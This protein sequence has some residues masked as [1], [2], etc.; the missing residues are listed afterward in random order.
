MY[1]RTWKQEIANEFDNAEAYMPTH[2]HRHAHS[3]EHTH[4]HAHTHALMQVIA[5]LREKGA[6]NDLKDATGQV[7]RDLRP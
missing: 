2:R 5:L 1:A 6:R 7:P 4:M 3:R